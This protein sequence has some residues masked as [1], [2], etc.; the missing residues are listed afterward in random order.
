MAG[1]VDKLKARL[2][3]R[4][5][6]R[7]MKLGRDYYQTHSYWQKELWVSRSRNYREDAIITKTS[8]I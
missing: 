1:I 6:P 5:C 8:P 4:F 2:K 7:K 3:K